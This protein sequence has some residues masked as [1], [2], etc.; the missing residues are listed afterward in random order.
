MSRVRVRFN[1]GG[2]LA[3]APSDE[4]NP[5]DINQQPPCCGGH[6]P[7]ARMEQR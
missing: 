4:P 3:V 5:V 7:I 2:W 6:F 1:L